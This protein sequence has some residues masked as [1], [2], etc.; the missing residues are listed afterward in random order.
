MLLSCHTFASSDLVPQTAA[1][2]IARP[3]NNRPND[4]REKLP[5]ESPTHPLSPNGLRRAQSSARQSYRPPKCWVEKFAEKNV[6]KSMKKV[7]ENARRTV[8]SPTE[9][10]APDLDPRI[11]D[12][13]CFYFS[14]TWNGTHSA[15][16]TTLSERHAA[17]PVGSREHGS[18]RQGTPAGVVVAGCPRSQTS[19]RARA[20]PPWNNACSPRR[21][22]HGIACDGRGGDTAMS[23][24]FVP[25]GMIDWTAV[26]RNSSAFFTLLCRWWTSLS[27]VLYM[28]FFQN[29]L[30]RPY[31]GR[32]SQPCALSL[33]HPRVRYDKCKTACHAE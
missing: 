28:Q 31:R 29:R 27:G 3:Q 9:A 17:Q 25:R 19:L 23:H 18:K 7:I 22:C 30:R 32:L 5:V 8:E 20:R 10:T 21:R 6:L 15:G 12:S 33:C 1:A 14:S 4:S 16:S 26:A 11:F 13:F 2:Q 24:H